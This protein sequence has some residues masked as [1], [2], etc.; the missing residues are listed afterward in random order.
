MAFDQST[1]NILKSFVNKA[2]KLLSDEFTRQLQYDYGMDP[3]T[4][5]ISEIN[6]LSRLDD[7]KMETAR[8]LRDTLNHYLASSPSGNKKEALDRIVREQAFTVLNRICALRM[9]EAR[10]ILI[11][12]T[13]NAYNSK[14]FQLY[15]RLAGTSLGESG[16]AYRCYLF[17]IFDEFA[18][19]LPVLFD[20]YSSMGRLFPRDSV[21]IELLE[22]I[23]ESEI[24]SFW[25][26]DETIGWIYQYFNSDEERGQ[27]RDE[28]NTPRNSREL[29]VRNQ[30]FTPRYVVEFLTDNTL[31]R[32]WYEMTKGETILKDNCHYLVRRPTEIFLAEGEETPKNDQYPENLDQEE[33][34]KRPVYVPFRPLKDPREIR[35][36]D[37]ACGS[38]HFGLYAFDLFEEIYRESWELEAKIGDKAF[39]RN[40]ELKPLQEIYP[41]KESLIRDVPKL[42]IE[43][44]IHGVDIDPRAV[45]IAG[46]SIWLRAQ[47][48]WKDQGIKPAERPQIRKSNIVCAEP[49]PG[50][51]DIL[52]E[53]TKRLKPKVLGQLVNI[54]FEKMELAGEAGSLVRIEGEIEDTIR[55]AENEFKKEIERRR[56]GV[57]QTLFQDSITSN[58]IGAFDFADLPNRTRFWGT[59]TQKIVEVLKDYSEHAENI[60]STEA[61]RKRLFAED[62]AK[63]FDF[64]D[65]FMKRFDIVLM[66][67]PFGE[68]S[69]KSKNYLESS[70]PNTKGDILGHF[71]ERFLNVISDN[72]KLGAITSRTCFFLGSMSNM[73]TKVLGKAGNLDIFVDL[74][75]GVLE[76]MVETACYV[77]NKSNN[78]K[79]TSIF[80]RC[81][82]DLNKE[83]S[84]YEKILAINSGNLID[85]TYCISTSIFKKLSGSPYCYWVST[86]IINKLSKLPPFEDTGALVKVGLQTGEDF[87]FLRNFWEVP[88]SEIAFRNWI[89]FTKTDEAIP[90]FSP[91]F[92][93]VKWRNNGSEILN[94]TDSNG[95]PRFRSNSLELYGRPG[96]SYMLRS[97]RL[98]PY[99]VPRNCIPT[100]G[101]SQVFPNDNL[102]I[103]ALA[104]CASNIGS[105][106]ARFRGEMF[107]RP[108]FQASMIQS[109]P[110][111]VLSDISKSTIESVINNKV[112]SARKSLAYIETSYDFIRCAE[113]NY[114]Q[115]DQVSFKSF[116]GKDIEKLLA[117]EYGLNEEELEVLEHDLQEAV[118]LR[119]SENINED[120][121]RNSLLDNAAG[122]LSYCV[123]VVF[124]RWDIRYATGEKKPPELLDPFDPLPVCPSGM[125]QNDK[126]LPAEAKDIHDDYPLR[127]CWDGILVD[128]E[129][130]PR[131]IVRRV[132]EAI[133]VIWKDKAEGTE[134]IICEIIGVS[135]LR[136]Y[137]RKPTKFFAD[138][139]KMYSK[140]RRQSP[141]Y[142][143]L[144]TPS[145]SYTLWVYYH[146]LTDQT[147][148]SCVNDFVDPK[149]REIS[150]VANNLRR[151][152]ERNSSEENEL[153]FLTEFELELKNLRDELLR[154]ARFWKPNLNDGVQIT[155]APLL[156]LFQYKPWNKSLKGIWKKM[157]AGDYDWAYQAYNIW[158]QRVREKCRTDKSLAIAHNLED[159]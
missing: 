72:G 147:L 47:R 101:R 83:R 76:A 134:Q 3:T 48:S 33:L 88:A 7:F 68:C 38:M 43:Y 124:C 96:F 22:I 39:Q 155:A 50:E 26:E 10:G 136:E 105:S 110:F 28:S 154:T 42:I 52:N 135:D 58:Q 125:L 121:E 79:T 113:I 99:I 49:M 66:N 65:L 63:G 40:E 19:D 98:V 70:F 82:L 73:R 61:T 80:C 67:P 107:A 34:L 156:N 151:K 132:L 108:K 111:K 142:W 2:R 60:N 53:F 21:L 5:E 115:N 46:L 51:K 138:H 117:N 144:S 20:R 119:S 57:Q 153:G 148:Y 137:F 120:N 74:G 89:P 56:E 127:P 71:I 141:I 128:D 17:S 44:N 92:L 97:T 139:L 75:D 106:V 14:G 9:A 114:I 32:I 84:L 143:P 85:N 59:V 91:I 29:A 87:R 16:D 130:H 11:E 78:K 90:W 55:L 145:G 81:L 13:G 146:R 102:E 158:P 100:A 129:G 31:G 24:K 126:G 30:F 36:L 123:G 37:P 131:D 1:R 45:Q 109:L 140:S 94:F 86:A 122:I 104:L 27:M 23:N 112:H 4:G 6:D 15:S 25:A 116:L 69:K 64:I 133:E 35:M 54:I 12:S 8:I 159:I 41:N 152:N 62:A 18:T 95:K 103:D 93:V 77:I 157:E 150:D 118:S 149:L